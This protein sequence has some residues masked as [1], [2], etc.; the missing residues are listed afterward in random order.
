M[1]TIRG[2]SRH[3]LAYVAYGVALTLGSQGLVHS[4]PH[5]DAA[6]NTAQSQTVAPA[7][8]AKAPTP[9][10]D[11]YQPGCRNPK[12][13]EEADSCHEWQA[14]YAEWKSAQ[15]AAGQFWVSLVGVGLVVGSFFATAL[16]AIAASKSARAAELAIEK[17]DEILAH[18]EEASERELRAYLFVRHGFIHNVG[19]V[20]ATWFAEIT[21]ENGGQTPAYE[22]VTGFAIRGDSWP[23]KRPMPDI[24]DAIEGGRSI[25]GPGAQHI[26]RVEPSDDIN[27]VHVGALMAK[28]A[29]LWVTGRVCYRDIFG[30]PQW[31][32]C[33]LFC[34]GK[35]DYK[36]TGELSPWDDGN[37]ASEQG[38]YKRRRIQV[39]T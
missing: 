24:P 28:K 30:D 38:Q 31:I 1:E 5:T 22:V 21:I 25:L 19:V 20:G 39:R 4:Q 32:T 16:A 23:L 3:W 11:G 27:E 35:S 34:G 9:E 2:H 8:T 7:T 6:T 26:V 36:P 14:A 37:D 15:W 29:T 18:S 13:R 33:R 12:T 10:G 17:S